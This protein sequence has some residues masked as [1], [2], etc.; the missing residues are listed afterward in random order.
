L[1]APEEMAEK[2]AGRTVLVG[3]IDPVLIEKGPA[4]EIR[5]AVRHLLD[6][7]GP[8]GGIIVCDGFNIPP[9]TPRE[10]LQAVMDEVAAFGPPKV[11]QR[12]IPDRR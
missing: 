5:K 6:V 1:N 9:G 4:A 3:N 2:M 7:L 12:P 8:F 10:H 11:T